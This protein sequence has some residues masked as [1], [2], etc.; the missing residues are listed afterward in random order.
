MQLRCA[1]LQ[2]VKAPLY[3]TLP[4][5]NMIAML[6]S[7]FIETADVDRFLLI[8]PD[9]RGEATTHWGSSIRGTRGLETLSRFTRKAGNRP[10]Q[11]PRCGREGKK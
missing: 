11:V 9:L 3:P 2:L 10:P 7:I 5:P 8:S 4:F 1:V 6:A